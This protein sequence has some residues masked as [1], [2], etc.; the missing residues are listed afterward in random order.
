M[1]IILTRVDNR[2][3]HGQVLETWVPYA[4][5]NS[6]IVFNDDVFNNRLQK[7]IIKA[8]V[9]SYIEVLI[10]RIDDIPSILDYIKSANI[11]CIVLLFNI[12]DALLAYK[13]GLPISKLN[14]G[15]IHCQPGRRQ[16]TQTI[17]LSNEEIEELKVLEGMGIQV[18][19]KTVPQERGTKFY[20]A[21]K[22]F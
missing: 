8:F 16:V 11:R 4:K 2:L 10:K 1:S 13:K 18:E 9:P 14:L 19:L 21:Y 7:E 22:N 6:I 17:Y 3:V 20:K 5:A 12:H 15:N